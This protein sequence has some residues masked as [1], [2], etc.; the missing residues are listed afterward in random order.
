MSFFQ[1][2]LLG[3]LQGVTEF[4]PV[5]SS[6][7][8]AVVRAYFMGLEQVP[9]LFDILLHTAT[10]AAILVVFRR[11]IGEIFFSLW[12]FLRR[13]SGE[14]DRENLRLIV[15]ILIATLATIVVGFGISELQD[16]L[17]LTE[18]TIGLRAVGVLFLV[19]ALVLFL[20]PLARGTRNYR[21]LSVLAGL[22]TGI[23]QGIGV[24]PGISRSGITLSASLAMG[25]ERNKAGEYA[26]LL[27]IPAVLGA[28]VLKARDFEQLPVDAVSLIA[29]MTISFLVGLLSLLLLL[30]LIRR[31][32]LFLFGF[33]LV[34]LGIIVLILG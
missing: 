27:S 16:R 32:R 15:I 30:R 2:I 24:L 26:F 12:R 4:L 29:G 19:T 11:R 23:A 28:L 22:F 21:D 25:M 31:G 6:G 9:I 5:S 10:L 18:G 8:L 1:S 20:S 7:H 33:Y 14:E 34:P 3:A 17:A 13:K